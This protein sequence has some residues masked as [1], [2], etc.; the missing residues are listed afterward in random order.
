MPAKTT[1]QML[2]NQPMGLAVPFNAYKH[3]KNQ[4]IAR[5]LLLKH[6]TTSCKY[7]L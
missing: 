7:L 6:K 4:P 5:Q 3:K 2:L 1:M